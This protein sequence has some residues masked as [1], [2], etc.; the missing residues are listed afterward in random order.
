MNNPNETYMNIF[1][2]QKMEENVVILI[3][4]GLI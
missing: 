3:M 2:S 1:L 4:P